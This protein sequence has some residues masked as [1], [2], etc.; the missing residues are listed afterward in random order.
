MSILV[1]VGP[2]WSGFKRDTGNPLFPL[3]YK[4]LSGKEWSTSGWDRFQHAHLEWNT[5]AGM[6]PTTELLSRV[7]LYFA[8]AGAAIAGFVIII[9]R[10][11]KNAPMILAVTL[12]FA[13][14]CATNYFHP[15]F[16]LPILPCVAVCISTH[17]TRPKSR[18]VTTVLALG[19]SLFAVSPRWAPSLKETVS[20]ALSVS[21]RENYM[22]R[23][24][25]EWEAIKAANTLVPSNASL[26]L[27]GYYS[28]PALYTSNALFPDY[29]LQDSVHYDTDE[30]IDAD[31][32]RLNVHYLFLDTHYPEWCS[33]SHRCRERKEN[34]VERTVS[35]AKR[36]G[37]LLFE[38]NGYTLY[39]LR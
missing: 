24:V 5:P 14:V 38:K 2:R 18:T 22:T 27:S 15:R 16:L 12:F 20:F 11:S 23:H 36:R 7:H 3:F 28:K 34:E 6:M 4:Q 19:L 31:L 17:I 25:P 1:P 39:H 10:R 35:L 32:V 8:L 26:L 33:T 21:S 13:A 37:T 29:A 30:H 9:T